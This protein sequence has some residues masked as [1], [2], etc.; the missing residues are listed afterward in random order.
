MGLPIQKA[1]TYTTILPSNNQ[2]VKYRP[3]LVKE[4]KYMLLLQ[5]S[6]S[7][8]QTVTAIKDMINAVTF[9]KLDIDELPMF[10]VEH[11][12][13]QVR[14]KSIGETVELNLRCTDR[15]CVGNGKTKINLDEVSIT[16]LDSEVETVVKITDEVGVGLKYPSIV[17][18][19]R[20]ED[21]E[22]RQEKLLTLLA[23]GIDY[24][25]D[26]EDRH[27]SED[28]SEEELREFLESLTMLQLEDISKFFEE[29]PA[30]SIVA[31]FTCDTCGKEQQ[32]EVRG[33]AS[34]F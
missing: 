26:A 17:D 9:G 32:R 16:G 1:P 30:V 18:M 15:G 3:F 19:G 12:F 6:G 28:I 24:V 2:E 34:F 13:L 5:D 7:A 33:L 4:Q 31:D 20:S 21:V 8:E 23:S 25:Y 10:D 27:E 11:L 22:D 14:A 29:L